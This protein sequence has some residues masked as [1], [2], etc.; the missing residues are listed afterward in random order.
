MLVNGLVNDF[1]DVD[2]AALVIKY[3]FNWEDIITEPKINV[4][5]P[6]LQE[7]KDMLRKNRL[8]LLDEINPEPVMQKLSLTY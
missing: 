1:L 8:F 7:H 3:V 4:T 5:M 2:H 6:M